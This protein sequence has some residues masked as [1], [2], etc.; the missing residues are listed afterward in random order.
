MALTDDQLTQY[1]DKAVTIQ[2]FII[3]NGGMARKSAVEDVLFNMY[4]VGREDA[5]GVLNY[6]EYHRIHYKTGQPA[7]VD[8]MRPYFTGVDAG[9]YRGDPFQRQS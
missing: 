9:W 8:D 1:R 3:E 2:R 5:H 4:G 6:I 7:T